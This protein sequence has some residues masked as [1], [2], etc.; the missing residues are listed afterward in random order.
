MVFHLDLRQLSSVACAAQENLGVDKLE[1]VADKSYYTVRN[2]GEVRGNHA[3][4][5]L[6]LPLSG[7]AMLRDAHLPVG[8]EAHTKRSLSVKRGE[9]Q[10]GEVHD[11]RSELHH[12][13][14]GTLAETNLPERL[15]YEAAD[16]FLGKKRRQMAK[17]ERTPMN[18]NRSRRSRSTEARTESATEYQR[19]LNPQDLDVRR[20]ARMKPF[21]GISPTP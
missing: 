4:H 10:W 9:M 5:L 1:V 7:E 14:K 20:E 12:D 13:F 18:A 3:M 11:W 17:H 2:H 19:R 15:D 21:A 6:R 16:R 8:V